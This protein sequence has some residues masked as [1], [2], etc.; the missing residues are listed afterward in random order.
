MGVIFIKTFKL[1]IH[2]GWIVKYNYF[3]EYDPKTDGSRH[4]EELCEDLLQ[5][6]NNNLL[7]DLGW[8]PE[9]DINGSYTLLLIDTLNDNAFDFP[10]MQFKTKD[11]NEILSKIEN[12]MDYDFIKDYLL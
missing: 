10:L 3:S 1:H 11:K 4:I 2:S 9:F 8:Y 6:E 7:I 12:W 5:L